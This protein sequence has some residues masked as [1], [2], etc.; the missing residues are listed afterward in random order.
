MWVMNMKK[1]EY[2]SFRVDVKTKE[3]L[4]LI[5][6]EK[7]W[8]TSQVVEQIVQDWLKEHTDQKNDS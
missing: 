2:L 8:S 6:E 5:A 7:K 1:S 3:K 4:K